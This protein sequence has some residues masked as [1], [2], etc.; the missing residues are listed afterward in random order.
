MEDESPALGQFVPKRPRLSLA[1]DY[2][3]REDVEVVRRRNHKR[4]KGTWDHIYRKYGKDFS[5]VGDE[6]DLVTGE[7]VVDNGHIGTME[8]E[9]DTGSRRLPPV[10]LPSSVPRLE[11]RDV[12][13]TPS[14][15]SNIWPSTEEVSYIINS[16][17]RH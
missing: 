15:G 6:I 16:L 11:P 1:N 17:F 10:S 14:E 4:L 13:P 9:R 2:E 8:S 12:S 5:E 7:V 3:E